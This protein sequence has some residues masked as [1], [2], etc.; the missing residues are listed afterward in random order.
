MRGGQ[1]GEIIR[2]TLRMQLRRPRGSS[3]ERGRR[4][5]LISSLV[6]YLVAGLLLALPLASGGDPFTISFTAT[7]AFMLLLGIFVVMEFATVVTGADD[8]AFYAP[9]PVAPRTYV[10]AKIIVA[11]LLGVSFAVVYALPAIIILPLRGAPPALLGLHLFTLLD[12]ALLSCLLFIVIFGL[13]VRVVPYRR[14]RNIAAWF[15]FAVFIAVYGG[16]AIFQRTLATRAAGQRLGLT[17]LLLLSP[18]AWGPSV[19]RLGEGTLPLVGLVLSIA[20]PLL[21]FAIAVRVVSKAYDG[22]L[23]EADV[24]RSRGGARPAR[25]G[26]GGALWRSPEERGVALLIGNLFRHDAQFRMGVLT[27]IPI[28][29]L[30]VGIIVL[31]NRAPIIDP[32]TAAG[33]AGFGPT[34]LLYLA[35]GF[36]PNYVKNALTYSSDAEASWLFY[37][38]PADP[39]LVI[40]AAR[41]FIV[42]FFI[43]PYLVLFAGVYAIVTGAVLHTVQH[44]AAIALLVLIETDLLLLFSPQ[45]PFSRKPAAGRRGGGMLLRLLAGAVLL[46]PIWL[47]VAF[48]YPFPGGWWAAIAVLCACLVVVRVTGR[49]FAAGKLAREEFSA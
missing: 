34:I 47:L 25:T 5:G 23:A 44:F 48:V 2:V 11:C 4:G 20:A 43:L 15:Q 35:L 46:L 8:L 42:T 39:L 14:V 16:S 31:V 21:L 1:A 32:F 10:V 38:S 27:I 9:L 24:A 29:I 37:S 6:V 45:V 7:T 36:Y 17:P 3:T 49:R 19:F 28:S 41:R 18:S 13:V 30:Y 33:R 26:G 22:K 40:R 12:G